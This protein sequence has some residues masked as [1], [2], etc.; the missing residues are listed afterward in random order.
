MLFGPAQRIDFVEKFA[1]AGAD[2][3]VLD[4]EDATPEAMKATAR[5]VLADAR[6]GVG[7]DGQMRLFVRTNSLGS[8]HFAQDLAAAA[9]AG[10][11]GIVVPKLETDREVADVRREMVAVGL[12]SSL[13]CAGIESAAGVH[14][15]VEVAGAGVD[16][17]YFGA[18]DF[19]TDIG[20][21]RTNGNAEVLYAR[22]RVAIAARMSGIPALDQVV[23]DYND[24]DRF[25]AEA[26]EARSLGYRGKLCIHPRQVQLATE[27]FSP[28]EDE[29]KRARALLAAAEAAE[30]T[31]RGVLAFEGTMV[32]API[33]RRA[34]QLL[35]LVE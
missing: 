33:I 30:A 25:R 21:V 12:E 28:S 18:E 7:L 3:G 22:S 24:D 4:L 27:A 9:V 31:G 17:V 15:C 19:I 20:G 35:D 26:F 23:V 6:P 14:R 8:E 34:R 32:D 10:A 5:D 2:I 16:L 29:V 11:H 1:K 13:L